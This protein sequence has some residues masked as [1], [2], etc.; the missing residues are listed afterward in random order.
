MVSRNH[1]SHQSTCMFT[2]C[3]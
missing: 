1:T 3:L 2:T